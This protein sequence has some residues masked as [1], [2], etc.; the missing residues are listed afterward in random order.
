M[1]GCRMLW[2]VAGFDWDLGNRAKCTKHGVPLAA[3]E[4][5]FH[6]DVRIAPDV[7]HSV[8]ELRFIAVGRSAQGRGLFVAFTLRGAED[9]L[10]IRPV[11]AR[12]MHR[13]EL[14]A[15]EKSAQA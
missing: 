7:K 8:A 5:L 10:L 13:K 2:K 15:Y 1:A 9:A 6:G 14:E 4:A 11:S 12:Y 3:V